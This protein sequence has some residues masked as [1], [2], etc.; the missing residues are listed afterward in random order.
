MEA[1]RQAWSLTKKSGFGGC[2]SKWRN[3]LCPPL[4]GDLG[5]RLSGDGTKQ[6]AAVRT[7]E[8][9]RAAIP[10]SLAVQCQGP[11][12]CPGLTAVTNS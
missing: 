5:S 12:Q 7:S 6:G 4:L 1:F 9:D 8:V 3:C 11:G 2:G 10:M